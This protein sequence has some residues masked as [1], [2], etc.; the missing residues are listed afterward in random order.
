MQFVLNV[1]DFES[2]DKYKLKTTVV[3]CNS[4]VF[5]NVY[6]ERKSEVVEKTILEIN[7]LIEHLEKHKIEL[8]EI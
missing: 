3:C 7:L 6:G 8:N 5:I 1:K 2:Y 4:T